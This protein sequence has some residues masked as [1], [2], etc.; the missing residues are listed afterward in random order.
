MQKKF[1]IAPSSKVGDFFTIGKKQNV[2]EEEFYD[3]LNSEVKELTKHKPEQFDDVLE[4]AKRHLNES[5]ESLTIK[6]TYF[7]I[8]GG[9]R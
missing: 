9:V 6:D 7:L 1:I 8:K 3:K 4:R 5:K 2:T